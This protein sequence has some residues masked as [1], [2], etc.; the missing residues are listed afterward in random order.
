MV[1]YLIDDRFISSDP[2]DTSAMLLARRLDLPGQAIALT[3]VILGLSISYFAVLPLLALYLSSALGTS[4]SAIGLVLG[5]LAV[6]SQG[7]QPVLGVLADRFGH[8]RA[9][10]TG[11]GF[12]VVGYAGFGLGPSLAGQL[13]CALTLGVGNATMSLVAKAMLANH[14]GDNRRAAFALRSVGVNVGAAIGPLLGALFFQR[15]E[16][17]LFGA[18]AAYLVFGVPLVA[19]ASDTRAAPEPGLVGRHVRALVSNRA[20]VGLASVSVGFWYLYTQ[21]N[22]A[23]P[24]YADD[25]FGFGGRVGLL[26]GLSAVIAVT[27]QYPAVAW[28]GR[29]GDG[30]LMLATGSLILAVA[31]SVLGAVPTT[32]ALFVFVV[33]FS[34]GE[35]LSVPALD[36]VAADLAPRAAMA[37]ALGFVSVGWAAGGLLGNVVGGVLYELAREHQRFDV[38]WAFNGV[39]AL[40][41]FVAFGLLRR[42]FGAASVPS[43][44]AIG[45]QA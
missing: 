26:F 44:V 45:E 42:R 12:A 2:T 4:P 29:R 24:L 13:A 37:G 7:L 38:F 3:G 33:V 41:T 5:V 34:L 1:R 28:F 22:L 25:R 15:F 30:W 14:A 18:A 31:F 17:A 20:L 39:V 43:A 8:R 36:I 27:L 9:L 19:L 11:V 23:F 40:A 32:G 35:L 10:R 16:V 21:F 6:T